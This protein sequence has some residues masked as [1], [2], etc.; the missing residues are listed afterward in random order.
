MLHDLHIT[1]SLHLIVLTPSD[2]LLRLIQSDAEFD[3]VSTREN[4]KMIHSSAD[5]LNAVVDDVLD[6]AKM[7]SGSVYQVDIRD[8]D[9]QTSVASVVHAMRQKSAA[10]NISIVTIFGATLPAHV[11][12]DPRRLQQILYNLL[13]NACKFSKDHGTVELHL[14]VEQGMLKIAIKDYGK[15]IAQENLASIFEPFRQ[16]NKETSTIYGGTGLGLS[17]TSKLV[18]RLGGLIEVDSVLGEY[19]QFTVALPLLGAVPVSVEAVKEQLHNTTIMLL[20]DQTESQHP[21][22]PA[23]IQEYGLDFVQ[24]KL[25]QEITDEA[26]KRAF[27][28]TTDREYVV[29]VPME[30]FH[31]G[32]WKVFTQAIAK[33][34]HKA[35]LI[36]YGFATQNSIT[37]KAAA[38]WNEISKLFPAHALQEI[39]GFLKKE[40]ALE[41]PSCPAGVVEPLVPPP[42]PEAH[43]IRRETSVSA[44]S[45]LTQ[46]PQTTSKS[47]SNANNACDDSLDNGINLLE[48]DNGDDVES[49]IDVIIVPTPP[50]LGHVKVVRPRLSTSKV[51]TSTFSTDSSSTQSASNEFV[52][53][54]T[55]AVADLKVMYAEDNKINQ[56]VLGRMLTKLGVQDPVIVDDGLAAVEQ[57]ETTSFDLIFMDI[58]M[59]IMDG[60]EAT[61]QIKLRDGENSPRIIFCTA[62][63]LQDFKDEADLAGADGFVA[64]PFNYQK[65]ELALKE[66]CVLK[67]KNQGERMTPAETTVVRR[68]SSFSM[69]VDSTTQAGACDSAKA[70]PAPEVAEKPKSIQ[71]LKILYAEDIKM[72]QKVMARMLKRLGI[73]DVEMVDNGEEAVK[74][75]TEKCFDLIFMDIQMPI[76]DGIE[77]TK[78]IRD[79][80]GKR[81]PRIIF[82]TAHAVQDF[83][84][85]AALSG[86]DG[87]LAKPINVEK[88]QTFL[89]D[90]LSASPS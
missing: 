19:A 70:S 87:F 36:L 83:K 64:K 66:A 29:I 54:S 61:S 18:E 47:A 12:T 38:H 33:E 9:L 1:Q 76:M 2:P 21:F 62:H 52:H 20:E 23:V 48:E 25:W 56:K 57:S 72:N 17:I 51:P 4:L 46:E 10:K 39:I 73:A 60:L 45:S 3:P 79:R 50:K 86:G 67:S 11:Q 89:E 53:P 81:G 32:N 13:G 68:D 80:D 75:T 58:Q 82:C 65:I 71:E 31:R 6:Y 49:P 84:D 22:S 26:E 7:E 78:K 30:R 42:K 8:T 85:K 40:S 27:A 69:S 28:G 44:F 41:A 77:A 14:F 59:P 37:G 88:I 63:A 34:N 35:L 15:G 5:L 90:A 74:R 16:E 43:M 55:C 24:H